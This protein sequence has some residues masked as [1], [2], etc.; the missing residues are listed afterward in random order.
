MMEYLKAQ[1]LM[2]NKN[3]LLKKTYLLFYSELYLTKTDKHSN[4]NLQNFEESIL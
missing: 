4:I 2:D 3:Y 1:I